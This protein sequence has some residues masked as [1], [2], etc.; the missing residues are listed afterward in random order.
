MS[1]KETQTKVTLPPRLNKKVLDL[2]ASL[3]EDD[4]GMFEEEKFA[5]LMDRDV[6]RLIS[7][8]NDGKFSPNQIKQSYKRNL[9][10]FPANS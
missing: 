7:F 5:D 3:R 10:A 1:K 6:K 2:V 4:E 8:A 9:N